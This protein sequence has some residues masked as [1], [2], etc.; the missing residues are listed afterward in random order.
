MRL[1]I[2]NAWRSNNHFQFNGNLTTRYQNLYF[3]LNVNSFE[4]HIAI[5]DQVNDTKKVGIN[6][7]LSRSIQLSWYKKDCP[8]KAYMSNATVRLNGGSQLLVWSSKCFSVIEGNRTC[9]LSSC[10][11]ILNLNQ[12]STHYNYPQYQAALSRAL[13]SFSGT[14]F[15]ETALNKFGDKHCLFRDWPGKHQCTSRSY[16]WR[17]Y[18]SSVFF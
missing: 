10:W 14:S 4:L 18:V 3:D 12:S 9:F 16:I 15:V 8:T 17:L 2:T 6:C 7:R 5:C 11:K 1:K 13:L